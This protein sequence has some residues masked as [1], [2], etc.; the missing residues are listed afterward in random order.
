MRLVGGDPS[1]AVPCLSARN[2]N[3]GLS[4]ETALRYWSGIPKG[5]RHSAQWLARA[6]RAYPGN[7]FPKIS[8]T[9]EELQQRSKTNQPARGIGIRFSE[10]FVSRWFPTGLPECGHGQ[11]RLGVE[12]LSETFLRAEKYGAESQLSPTTTPID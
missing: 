10:A 6:A 1:V 7:A 9:L 3:A 11:G 4:D 2:V 5:L 8:S 12:Y